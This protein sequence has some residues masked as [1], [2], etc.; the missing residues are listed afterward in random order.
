[1]GI[2]RVA[3]RQGVRKVLNEF[4]ACFRGQGEHLEKNSFAVR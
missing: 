3:H 4:G 1:M 2:H